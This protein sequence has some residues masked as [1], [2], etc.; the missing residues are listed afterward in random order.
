MK[1][2]SGDIITVGDCPGSD[3][4]VLTAGEVN[5]STVD[6]CETTNNTISMNDAFSIVF[7]TECEA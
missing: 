6:C 3:W 5:M 1:S 2:N 4:T 7:A